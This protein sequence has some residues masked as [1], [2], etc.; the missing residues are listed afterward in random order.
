MPETDGYT[1]GLELGEPLAFETPYLLDAAGV[2]DHSGNPVGPGREYLFT[3]EDLFPPSLDSAVADTDSSVVL[4][5]DEALDGGTAEEPANYAVYPAGHPGEGLPLLDA[6]LLPAADRV[7]LV[8]EAPFEKYVTYVAGATGVEDLAGNATPPGTAASF[9]LPDSIPPALLSAATVSRTYVDVVF[10]ER[11]D[12]ASLA[13]P[14]KYTLAAAADSSQLF[15]VHDAEPLPD[16][17]SVRL[18]VAAL[19]YG[20]RYRLTVSN[21]IDLA[22]NGIPPG[23]SVEFVAADTDPPRLLSVSIGGADRITAHFSEA[24]D[25]VTAGTRANY[26]VWQTNYPAETIAVTAAE[27]AGDHVFLTLGG[28]TAANVWYTLSVSGVADPQ[29]NVIAPDSR[30][31][32]RRVTLPPNGY[33]GLYADEEHSRYDVMNPGGFHPFEM[34]IWCLPSEFGMMC[35]EF[36]IQYPQN[37]IAAT[38][39][40]SPLV[41]VYLGDLAAGMSACFSEC[42]W[43]WSWLFR[44]QCYLTDM[45]ISS[46]RIVAHPAVDDIQ[47]ANCQSGYPIYPAIVLNDLYL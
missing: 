34:W 23:S 43:E 32:F 44:Q 41:S 45:E 39:T 47:F 17:A 19:D 20:V 40:E 33:I 26:T 6:V 42:S 10:D 13:D 11:M 2:E 15:A 1:V 30:A 18:A 25:P 35:A 21:V 38:V 12:A 27:P 9:V 46:I 7:R 8:A 16:T 5:F 37:V 29:G 36:A 24:V 22:G 3:V 28:N 14:G 31:E 4:C